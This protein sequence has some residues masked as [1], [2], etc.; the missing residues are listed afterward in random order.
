MGKDCPRE[1][2]WRMQ[3]FNEYKKNR[4]YD[5]TF[6]GGPFF[7][8]AYRDDLFAAGGGKTILKC[9]QLEAD[10]CIAFDDQVYCGK[11]SRCADL[12]YYE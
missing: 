4:V 9:P 12:N 1:T 3:L 6:M 11:L 5:D 2:I 7:E 10:D 8:M